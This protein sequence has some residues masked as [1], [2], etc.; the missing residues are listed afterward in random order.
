MSRVE[1]LI[2]VLEQPNIEQ[3]LY[4]MEV[5]SDAVITNQADRDDK[6]ILEFRGHRVVSGT[7]PERGVGKSRNRCL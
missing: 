4:R 6:E 1:L 7:S 2:S 5:N 3:L